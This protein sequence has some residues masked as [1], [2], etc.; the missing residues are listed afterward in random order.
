MKKL[1]EEARL[2]MQGKSNTFDKKLE[3]LVENTRLLKNLSEV[4]LKKA[5]ELNAKD[6]T[7]T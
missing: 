3:E 4:I 5:K 7:H 1:E 6:N 2:F